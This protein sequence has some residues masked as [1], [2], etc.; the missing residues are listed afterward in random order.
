MTSVSF[1]TQQTL[2]AAF[3]EISAGVT[4]GYQFR[5]TFFDPERLNMRLGA[6][7]GYIPPESARV[8]ASDGSHVTL[9]LRRRLDPILEFTF[10]YLL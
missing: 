9:S 2:G 10:G 6:G 5:M 4:A 7:I 1:R 3:Q 8:E